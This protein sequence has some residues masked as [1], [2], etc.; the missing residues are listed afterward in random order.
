MLFSI[1]HDSKSFIGEFTL[2]SRQTLLNLMKGKL[3]FELASKTSV[4]K[5]WSIYHSSQITLEGKLILKKKKKL[6]YSQIPLQNATEMWQEANGEYTP[7]R[8][9]HPSDQQQQDL[10]CPAG[11]RLQNSLKKPDICESHKEQ[12]GWSFSI[13]CI[14]LCMDLHPSFSP[15]RIPVSG[16]N[17]DSGYGGPRKTELVQINWVRKSKQKFSLPHSLTSKPSFSPC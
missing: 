3:S 15:P 11:S 6:V 4:R 17:K 5:L 9:V 12:E 2:Q 16:A 14:S 1:H 13:T 10:P 7:I 8:S